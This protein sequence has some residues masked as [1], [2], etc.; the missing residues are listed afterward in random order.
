MRVFLRTV[1]GV[2]RAGI[3]SGLSLYRHAMHRKVYCKKKPR[4]VQPPRWTCLPY[5][6][7]WGVSSVTNTPSPQQWHR[8]SISSPPPEGVV[9][10]LAGNAPVCA[11]ILAV[12]QAFPRHDGV[13]SMGSATYLPI[14]CDDW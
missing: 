12:E 1:G 6:D 10:L 2:V 5:D 3:H 11:G 7:L 8:V 9:K 14:E 4:F 13:A